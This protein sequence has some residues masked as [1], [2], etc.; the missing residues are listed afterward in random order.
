M[1]ILK[2]KAAHYSFC[3]CFVFLFVFCFLTEAEHNHG[4]FNGNRKKLTKSRSREHT[5]LECSTDFPLE[6]KEIKS[7]KGDILHFFYRQTEETPLRRDLN[8]LSGRG[9]VPLD[10]WRSWIQTMRYVPWLFWWA[11]ITSG[12]LRLPGDFCTEH[13]HCARMRAQC[14][15]TLLEILWAIGVAAFFLFTL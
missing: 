13:E 10:K 3:L 15:E 11:N 7:W 2:R 8:W 12:L 14:I 9:N 1:S 5:C 6:P 4:L